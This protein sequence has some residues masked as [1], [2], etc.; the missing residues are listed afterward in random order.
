SRFPTIELQFIVFPHNRHEIDAVKVLAEE[1]GVET[2]TI[3]D[4]ISNTDVSKAHLDENGKPR[5]PDKCNALYLM[6][7]FNWD[8]SMSPCCDSVDDSFG[9]ILQEDFG[10]LW[11]S[12]KIIKSRSLQTRSPIQG[13]PRTKC[14]RCRIYG[15]HV[16]FL[17]EQGPNLI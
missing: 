10:Q 12:P 15:N 13:G 4:S 6:S 16:L 5:T 3:I 7:C 11:N 9:N 1:L 17:P 14:E 2:L 8:G